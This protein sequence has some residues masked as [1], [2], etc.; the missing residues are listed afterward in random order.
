LVLINALDRVAQGDE[1]LAKRRVATARE[2][3]PPPLAEVLGD[4]TLG[5]WTL[6]AA[7]IM[8]LGGQIERLRP[9][10]VLELGS[11]A[12]TACIAHALH[13]Q[14]LDA[15]LISVDHDARWLDQMRNLLVRNGLES[16]VC[17]IH[18]PLAPTELDG[19]DAITYDVSLLTPLLRT[20]RP[21]FL[22]ID[23]PP[24]TV[25]NGR[26]ATLPMLASLV[27]PGAHWLLDDA[28]TRVG[29]DIANRW[30]RNPAIR[31]E[32]IHCVGNGLLAGIVR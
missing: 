3:L 26:Y 16:R 30:A 10:V 29:I 20:H 14:R 11:G 15:T 19:V 5:E 2:G 4:I 8:F 12:S 24:R 1:S 23:G 13:Q 31:V 25:T 9:G 17:L 32:G 18:A 28:L 22:F 21:S 7:S 6:D 27:E